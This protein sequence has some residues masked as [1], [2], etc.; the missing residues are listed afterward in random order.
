MG[1]SIYLPSDQYPSSQTIQCCSPNI[2]SQ[3]PVTEQQPSPDGSLKNKV[4][5]K[6]FSPCWSNWRIVPEWMKVS[7][8]GGRVEGCS[9]A[10]ARLCV[11]EAQLP[12][13]ASQHCWQGSWS[14]STTV[15]LRIFWFSLLLGYLFS[16]LC[17]YRVLF[18]CFSFSF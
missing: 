1:K 10:G 9:A 8:G 5:G 16:V 6:M 7:E 11:Q 12:F 14:L 17:C 13:L 4:Q 15:S 2:A 3:A 18:F